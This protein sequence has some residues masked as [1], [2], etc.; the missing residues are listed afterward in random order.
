MFYF[1]AFFAGLAVLIDVSTTT[2]LWKKGEIFKETRETSANTNIC[3]N[4]SKTFVLFVIMMDCSCYF[5][6]L[7]GLTKTIIESMNYFFVHHNQSFVCTVKVR[8]D[9]PK[10][11]QSKAQ[12][13]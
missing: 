7:E 12:W 5:V 9:D 6:K 3:S 1:L 13:W 11:L 4:L 10:L 8:H 2:I